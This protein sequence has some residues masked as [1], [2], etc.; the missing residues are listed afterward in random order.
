[1]PKCPICLNLRTIK[2]KEVPFFDDVVL[3]AQSGCSNCSLIVKI[4]DVVTS[5]Y[6]APKPS[7]VRWKKSGNKLQISIIEGDIGE[8]YKD[9][10]VYLQFKG[11]LSFPC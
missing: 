9:F 6:H 2:D 8:W 3:S 10:D 4:V 11:I 7:M 5:R 1:M